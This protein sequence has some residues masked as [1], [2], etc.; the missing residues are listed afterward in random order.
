MSWKIK[1]IL[2]GLL[3]ITNACIRN[4]L[5]MWIKKQCWNYMSNELY[6]FKLLKV[7]HFL[8]CDNIFDKEPQFKMIKFLSEAMEEPV[9][10][11]YLASTYVAT[12]SCNHFWFQF[13]FILKKEVLIRV[14]SAADTVL[15][16]DKATC[17]TKEKWQAFALVIMMKI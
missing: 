17:W 10:A 15:L 6:V 5:V 13:S 2:D 9:I 3:M 16:A 4:T 12:N 1:T 14:V 11:Q 8:A 7:V